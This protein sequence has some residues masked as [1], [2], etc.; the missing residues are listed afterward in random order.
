MAER[1]ENH[2]HTEEVDAYNSQPAG[3]NCLGLFFLWISRVR[4]LPARRGQRY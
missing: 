1:E 2:G 4:L 3:A